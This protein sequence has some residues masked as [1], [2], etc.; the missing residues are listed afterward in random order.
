MKKVIIAMAISLLFPVSAFADSSIGIEFGFGF[1]ESGAR[2]DSNNKKFR[3]C[4][5]RNWGGL[6]TVLIRAKKDNIELHGGRWWHDTDSPNCNR[7]S[8]VIG[9]GYE[10][11]T[12]GSGLA[13]QRDEYIT[14]TPG[15]SYV[16]GPTKAFSFMRTTEDDT[17]TNWRL[18]TGWHMFNRVAVGFGDENSAVEIAVSHY[19]LFNDSKVNQEEFLTFGVFK[20]KLDNNKFSNY[21]PPVDEPPVDEPPV[22]EPPVD[23]PKPPKPPKECKPGFGYGDS[24]CHTGPPGQ[25]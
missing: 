4:R 23:E 2:T 17:S 12:E 10:F 15:I 16:W 24:R 25:S 5:N 11:S 6:T 3:L 21:R 9:L 1:G 22:D 7:T 20:K 18:S 8:N 13:G 19:G 14:Y